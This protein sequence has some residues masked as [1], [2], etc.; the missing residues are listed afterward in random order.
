MIQSRNNND[1]YMP[2]GWEQAYDHRSGRYFYVDHNSQKTTWLNPA[3]R[4]SKPRS[5]KD[6]IGDQLP[7]GWERIID[8]NVGTY[9][10]DHLNRRNTWEDPVSNWRRQNRI[11]SQHHYSNSQ[12]PL[13]LEQSAN[14]LDSNQHTTSS[15]NTTDKPDTSYHTSDD[16]EKS[17]TSLDRSTTPE[18]DN[19]KSTPHSTHSNSIVNSKYDAGLLDIMDNCFGRN[20]SQSVEV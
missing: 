7:Y 6:C 12:H 20:S 16:I 14:S 5:V 9:Y 19:I 2:S 15:P 1:L 18:S 10:T 8:P 4:F 13:S 17:A 11:L 3:D